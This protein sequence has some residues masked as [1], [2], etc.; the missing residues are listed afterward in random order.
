MSRLHELRLED[1]P[2]R[3]D[4]EQAAKMKKLKSRGCYLAGAIGAA[5]FFAAL[6]KV[7]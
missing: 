7:L 2:P 4:P 5:I 3:P 6:L 1:R